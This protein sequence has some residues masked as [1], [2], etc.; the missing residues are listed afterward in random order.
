MLSVN[1]ELIALYWDIG[2]RI[3]ERQEREGWGKSV[4]D[5]LAGDLQKAFPGIRGFS[6]GNVWRMRAFFFAYRPTLQF[7]AQPARELAREPNVA[8]AVRQI[9]EPISAQPVPKSK[10]RTLAQAA[11]ETAE[12]VQSQL[13]TELNLPI[14]PQPV[15]EIPWG[16]NILIVEKLKDRSERLWYAAKTLEHG[17]SRAVL[18]LQIE[19]D[20]HAR[21][22]QAGPFPARAAQRELTE[23]RE[24]RSRTGVSRRTDARCNSEAIVKERRSTSQ[25]RGRSSDGIMKCESRR[26]SSTICR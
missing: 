5:R 23:Y 3:V 18:T 2:R 4:V 21:Q 14:L 7:L 16:H 12:P 6:P 11:R 13:V 9:A 17:C 25:C 20:L 8:Q 1:R 10:R 19:S 26:S 15:A 24:N 22:D